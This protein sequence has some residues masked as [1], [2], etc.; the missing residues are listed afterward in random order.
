MAD[1]ISFSCNHCGML[2]RVP[3]SQAGRMVQCKQCKNNVSVP[4]Q[5][6]IAAPGMLDTSVE[7][8]AGDQ[9]LRKETS[10]RTAPV[11]RPSNRTSRISSS[12]VA[13]VGGAAPIA[14]L[15][16]IVAPQPQ[17]SL[18]PIIIAA[19]VVVVL[20][21][22]VVLL[23]V[24]GTKD[25]G[26]GHKVS[27]ANSA[28][29][30]P[31][32]EPVVL[33]ESDKIRRELEDPALNAEKALA[34][35]RRGQAAKLTQAEQADIARRVLNKLFDEGGAGYTGA[36]VLALIDEF[37][38]FD[39]QAEAQRLVR[40]VVARVPETL[41]DGKAND[42][43][44][45]MQKMLGR[46]K[47]DFDDMLK[48]TQAMLEAEQD[49]AP[50]LLTELAA[51][52]KTAVN[53]WVERAEA[54]KVRT[55]ASR[56]A[57]I[58]QAH[59]DLLRDNPTLAADRERIKKFKT[60]R[61]A[62]ATA[63]TYTNT[64]RFM[65]YVQLTEQERKDGKPGEKAAKERSEPLVE[66]ARRLGESFMAD[67]AEPLGLTR[68]LPKA[69]SAEER[70]KQPIEI[71]ICRDTRSLINYA[72]Y[73]GETVEEDG[74]V[75][76]FYT[77]K[78]QRV[79]VSCEGLGPGEAT[80]LN[81]ALNLQSLLFNYY[82]K[83]PLLRDEDQEQ[84]GVMHT[85]L[86]DRSLFR[87][88]LTPVRANSLRSATGAQRS[89]M[90]CTFFDE[91]AGLSEILA[92]WRK[93]FARGEGGRG[94]DSFGGPAFSVR[95]LVEM[96]SVEHGCELMRQ[97]FSKLPGVGEELAKSMAQPSNLR[98][99]AT[100]YSDALLL[101]LYHFQRDDK[102]VYREGLMKF[103]AK[104]LQGLKRDESLKGF[105]EALGLNDAKWKQLEDEFA[106]SQK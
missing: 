70:E 99:L 35:F 81:F 14:P 63:W 73:I 56:L 101:F 32:A 11:P 105:E 44:L 28:N 104:D 16:R 33:S 95:N 12:R 45:R 89:I 36:Q 61:A 23:F 84:R 64:G 25:P 97:N 52:A 1:V 42:S 68:S 77:L 103:I 98:T 8:N 96:R 39:L 100:L 34:L 5:S 13:P 15:P 37:G 31:K 29:D 88:I 3:Y 91:I 85:M 67:W 76:A 24:L 46:E 66:V 43:F 92:R 83:D 49:G 38:A 59:K 22:L 20:G 51:S 2:Y 9:V 17:K 6:Q 18:A 71:V 79:C 41:P 90:N 26:A 94:I 75:V 86:L 55:Q 27:A 80:E 58:E 60:E 4:T 53:G 87:C 93:P 47:F 102:P 57:Q 10:A 69:L 19:V 74:S 7:M 106:A 78:S 21:G 65:F 54:E 72:S 50:E 48:R 40:A 62:R 30:K 82:S